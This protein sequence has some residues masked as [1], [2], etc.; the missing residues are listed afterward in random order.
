MVL[1]KLH[2]PQPIYLWIVRAL[3]AE[4]RATREKA[5]RYIR[6]LEMGLQ[7]ERKQ[8]RLNLLS[9]GVNAASGFYE[10]LNI[11]GNKRFGG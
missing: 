9:S 10:Q 6:N 5:M 11:G 3:K 7:S 8:S 1:K 2:I 4:K